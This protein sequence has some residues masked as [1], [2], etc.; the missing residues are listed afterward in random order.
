[1]WT[2]IWPQCFSTLL[3]GPNLGQTFFTWGTFGDRLTKKRDRFGDVWGTVSPTNVTLSARS[4]LLLRLELVVV[5]S[6][7][8]LLLMS[9]PQKVKKCDYH[10][11]LNKKVSY[12]MYSTSIKNIGHGR[13][14]KTSY[15]IFFRTRPSAHR[16]LPQ[17]YKKVRKAFWF[18]TKC[19]RKW[20]K[21]R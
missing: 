15:R 11:W 20:R 7:R 3:F 1:M 16:I 14:V 13:K 21:I 2:Q 9:S 6:S 19:A 18:G 17:K 12:H 5:S 10:T 4:I 8:P